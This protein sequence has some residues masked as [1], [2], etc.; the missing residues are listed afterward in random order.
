MDGWCE[1]GTFLKVQENAEALARYDYA[2]NG[3]YAGVPYGDVTDG[4]P[5][6]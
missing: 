6:N 5:N 4:A 2:C 1:L 3:D